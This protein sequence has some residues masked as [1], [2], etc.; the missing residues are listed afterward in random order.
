MLIIRR[1]FF[2]IVSKSIHLRKKEEK[3]QFDHPFHM[4]KTTT[5]LC[6][7]LYN[8]CKS[9]LFLYKCIDIISKHEKK[10]TL[11]K[12]CC[13]YNLFI[14]VRTKSLDFFEQVR[15]DCRVVSQ[16][17]KIL[18]IGLKRWISIEKIFEF[19]PL[20]TVCVYVK[21]RGWCKKEKV[22]SLSYY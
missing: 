22:E 20:C 11:L 21:E 18:Q 7:S 12:K 6:Y 15:I 13:N 17:T 8:D 16:T 10:L 14:I 9:T 4:D 1:N 19:V 5:L 3:T 2:I